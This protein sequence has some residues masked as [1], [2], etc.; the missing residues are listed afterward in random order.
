MP[1]VQPSQLRIDIGAGNGGDA[2]EVQMLTV[3]LRGE[4][5]V[6]DIGTVERAPG[7]PPPEGA[8]GPVGDS[9]GTLLITLSNSAV[10]A[11]LVS[12]FQSWLRRNRGR[13]ITIQLG[14]DRIEARNVPAEELSMLIE[15]WMNNREQ[16]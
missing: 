13:S 7:E 11:S 6:S 15:T 12:V 9:A 14:K 8:K 10:V 1:G 3:R 4:L 2:E 5:L 16:D